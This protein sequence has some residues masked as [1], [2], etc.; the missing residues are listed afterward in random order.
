LQIQAEGKKTRILTVS[1]VTRDIKEVLENVFPE[2]W[3]QGEITNL[4]APSSGHLYF[5]LKDAQSSL[6][7]VLF[8]NNGLRL[9]FQPK[10]GDS[11]VAGGRIGLYERDGQYQLYIQALEPKGTG[12]LQLA[13]EQ[14]KAK[15]AQEGLF[16]EGRK[17]PLPF[18]P[19]AIGIVT[20]P[21]GAVIR[22]ILHVLE[23]RFSASRVILN[24]VRVQG[25]GA[26]QEIACAIRELNELK[27]TDV[28]IVA[29]GGGSLEDLWCFNEEIVA[30]AIASSEIP[31]VSAIG[32]ETDWT[33][34]DFVADRR[35]PTPS[36][37]AE[38]VM[39]A[40][41]ELEDRI[42]HFLRHLWRSLVD[43]VP[44]HEQHLDSLVEE[45]GR[46]L[47]QK[48]QEGRLGLDSLCRRL[49]GLNPL[50]I[51][52][53]GYSVTTS[54]D[55][56]KVVHNAAGL[57]PGD[58]LRTRLAEGGFISRVEEVFLKDGSGKDKGGPHGV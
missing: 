52:R 42:H 40:R 14:L 48:F 56:K 34:A 31:V 11:V 22:D 33:I 5:S 28:I 41:Q 7:C 32:H 39:P 24:P 26:A 3:V 13:F 29:R 9:K 8:K 19:R 50:A 17:R 4:R 58:R 20:S 45:M 10:D 1:E 47:I 35:A 57:A 27:S 37:A 12:S 25:E 49:E 18:L 36:A 30:R 46:C 23:R 54:A 6:R 15:L 53:R 55:G 38:I 51:L 16:D 21:T 44:Q 2:V 43:V